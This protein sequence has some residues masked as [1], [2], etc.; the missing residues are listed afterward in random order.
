VVGGERYE[1]QAFLGFFVLI[2]SI[3]CP[4]QLFEAF[5]FTAFKYIGHLLPTYQLQIATR[6]II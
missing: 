6:L 4:K 1:D 5:F 2:L 3:K